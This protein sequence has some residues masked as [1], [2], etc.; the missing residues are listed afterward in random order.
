[1]LDIAQCFPV[2]PDLQE[3]ILYY[4][5]REWAGLRD[6]VNMRSQ[7]RMPL[8]KQLFEGTLISG[9]NPGEQHFLITRS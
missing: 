7:Q 4:F 1:M 6:P 2:V 3:Y 5:F 9:S 8:L